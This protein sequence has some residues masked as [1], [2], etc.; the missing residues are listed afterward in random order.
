MILELIVAIHTGGIQ[1]VPQHVTGFNE[2]PGVE[3]EETTSRAV[4]CFKKQPFSEDQCACTECTDTVGCQR[5]A[6]FPS[7]HIVVEKSM[8]SVACWWALIRACLQKCW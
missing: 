2:T 7:L 5:R 8:H 3:G 1:V 6:V 4:E